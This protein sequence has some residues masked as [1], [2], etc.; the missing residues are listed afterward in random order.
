MNRRSESATVVLV[1]HSFEIRTLEHGEWALLRKLRLRA[2]W[3]APE[4]FGPSVERERRRTT[5]YWRDQMVLC[6]WFVAETEH[7]PRPAAWCTESDDA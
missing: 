6:L 3:E 5:S 7:R 1:T 2:L 4:A